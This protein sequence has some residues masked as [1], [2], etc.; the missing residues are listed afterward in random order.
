METLTSTHEIK[1]K[2]LM[3]VKETSEIFDNVII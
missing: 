3:F 2:C 1:R